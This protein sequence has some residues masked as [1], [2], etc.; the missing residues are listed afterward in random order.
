MKKRLWLLV[1]A[2]ILVVALAAPA[3]FGAISGN[4][5]NDQNQQFFNQMFDGHQ[6]WLD[7]A[8]KDGQITPEQAQTWQDHFNYMRDFHNKNGMGPMGSMMGGSG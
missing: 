6:K 8:Q 1:A 5:Q 3:A 4:G 2:G 7:Q